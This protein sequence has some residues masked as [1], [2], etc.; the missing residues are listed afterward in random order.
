MF[1]DRFSDFGFAGMAMTS[2]ILSSER[3]CA[4]AYASGDL[5]SANKA[6][7]AG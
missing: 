5:R 6:T 4:H 1:N 3:G 7:E 2:P